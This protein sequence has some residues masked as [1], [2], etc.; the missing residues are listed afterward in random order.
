MAT[1]KKEA[2]PTQVA[3]APA[4]KRPAKDAKKAPAPKKAKTAEAPKE[5]QPV[6]ES[7]K[8]AQKAKRTLADRIHKK[9]VALMARRKAQTLVLMSR[10]RKYLQEYHAAERDV[11]HQRRQARMAGN[12]YREADPKLVFV[13]R[14]KGILGLSPR[15]RKILRLLR[16][17]QINNGTF[18]R[19]TKATA[20]MLRLVSPYVTYGYPNLKSVKELIYKRGFG[21]ASGRRAALDNAVIAKNLGRFGIICIEDLIHEIYTVGKHFKQANKFLWTFKLSNPTGGFN[22]KSISYCEGG[23]YGNREEQLNKLL[24]KMV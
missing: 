9:R 19:L 23:D 2:A 6:P 1:E 13:I 3:P 20:E 11:I 7:V 12:F 22:R 17:R 21:R 24:R 8:K 15:T 4:A 10:A 14:L 16:L 5:G 18:V